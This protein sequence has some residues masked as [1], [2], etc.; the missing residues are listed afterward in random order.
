MIAWLRRHFESELGS[1]GMH[2][3]RIWPDRNRGSH[4]VGHLDR[5]T[6]VRADRIPRQSQS[7][8]RALELVSAGAP[9]EDLPIQRL[10]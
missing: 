3:V 6:C 2:N 10:T 9:S 7:E 8:R 4:C 5:Q 1:G